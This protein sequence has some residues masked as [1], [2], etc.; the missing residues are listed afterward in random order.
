MAE[1]VCRSFHSR[2]RDEFLAI[3]GFETLGAAKRLTPTWKEDYNNYRPQ[4][5]LADRAQRRSPPRVPS[6]LPATQLLPS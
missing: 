1:R 3:E 5:S 4:S 6:A 2:L